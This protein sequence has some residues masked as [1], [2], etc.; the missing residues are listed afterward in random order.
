MERSTNPYQKYGEGTIKAD[1][2]A[3]DA[4]E[5][6]YSLSGVVRNKTDNGQGFTHKTQ[7]GYVKF[8]V[9][10]AP[11]MSVDKLKAMGDVTVVWTT[12]TKQ[13]YTAAHAWQE[14]EIEVVKDGFEVMFCYKKHQEIVNG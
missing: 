10:L 6:G 4:T 7:G 5:I 12:D 1:G 14:G 9:E 11:G 8:K 13:T 3:W 2:Q